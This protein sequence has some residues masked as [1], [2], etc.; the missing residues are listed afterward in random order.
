MSRNERQSHV[1]QRRRRP[2]IGCVLAGTFVLRCAAGA[3]GVMI[4]F[5]FEYIDQNVHP[6]SNTAGGLII[7]T[8]FAAELLGAPGFWRPQ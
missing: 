7:A 2:F 5:Y 8:F 4:Q 6:I 3:M 1:V